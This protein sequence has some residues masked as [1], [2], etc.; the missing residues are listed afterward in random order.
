MRRC[1][2]HGCQSQR[3]H[4]ILET[5]PWTSRAVRHVQPGR[6]VAVVPS[7]AAHRAL[8]VRPPKLAFVHELQ[9]SA[10]WGVHAALR[11]CMIG[12]FQPN[13]GQFGC[14]SCDIL[15]DF[16]QELSAQSSCVACPPNTRRFIGVLSAATKTSCQ[17]K[18]G[19]ISAT[20]P[21]WLAC[22]LYLRAS[23]S[24]GPP[25]AGYHNARLE[26]GEVCCSRHQ[27]FPCAASYESGLQE[28]AKCTRAQA[29]IPV[30][31]PSAARSLFSLPLRGF[32]HVFASRSS[33][34]FMSWP[35]EPSLSGF[36]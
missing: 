35:V 34:R 4:A 6:H 18:E 22:A 1:G 19:A 32:S 10:F 20:S 36:G 27:S 21:R 16:Y 7:T 15:G 11:V 3:S 24:M 33:K 14:I 23:V 28:C 12:Y 30:A 31:S 2:R 5:T 29:P 9:S 26:A 8:R 17:C 25:T 13:Q